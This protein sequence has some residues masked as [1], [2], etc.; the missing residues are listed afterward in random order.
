M[1][2][3][4][5]DR[6]LLW[7]WGFRGF[8]REAVFEVNLEGVREKQAGLKRSVEVL[9]LRFRETLSLCEDLDKDIEGF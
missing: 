6:P 2:Y 9:S 8:C 7:S 3:Q 1:G 5:R 4:V